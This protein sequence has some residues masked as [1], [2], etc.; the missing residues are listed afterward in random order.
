MGTLVVG[1]NLVLVTEFCA[2]LSLQIQEEITNYNV[3][4]CFP[5]A[6]SYSEVIPYHRYNYVD[7][8]SV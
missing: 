3:T 2:H 8:H 7:C 6:R 4:F 5:L 1:K